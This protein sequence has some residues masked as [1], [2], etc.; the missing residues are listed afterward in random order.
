[1]SWRTITAKQYVD[2]SDVE[3]FDEARIECPDG[4]VREIWDAGYDDGGD[5]IVIHTAMPTEFAV[6]PSAPVRVR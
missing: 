6:V 4:R 3:G 2:N 1:M 5:A